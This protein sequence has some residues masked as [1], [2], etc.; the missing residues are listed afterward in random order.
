MG[1]SL[2]LPEPSL[3]TRNCVGCK[4]SSPLTSGLNNTE[5]NKKLRAGKRSDNWQFSYSTPKEHEVFILSAPK[6]HILVPR[7]GV[8]WKASTPMLHEHNNSSHLS[9]LYTGI[10][11][12]GAV[13]SLCCSCVCKLWT[14]AR[15]MMRGQ[16]VCWN[17]GWGFVLTGSE[18][19]QAGSWGWVVFHQ[20]NQPPGQSQTHKSNTTRPDRHSSMGTEEAEGQGVSL[21]WRIPQCFILQLQGQS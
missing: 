18:Q 8:A 20:L 4:Y 5:K 21:P 7:L 19:S 12:A 3:P 2:F 10:P 11:L 14:V 1:L 17:E 6:E 13:S 9:L 16:S 15:M